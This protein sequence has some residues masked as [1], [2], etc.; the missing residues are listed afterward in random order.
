M[1]VRYN[2][3]ISPSI[4]GNSYSS[5]MNH[6]TDSPKSPKTLLAIPSKAT[7]SADGLTASARS[8]FAN[9]SHLI[10]SSSTPNNHHH[11]QR[12]PPKLSTSSLSK[13]LQAKYACNVKNY[14]TT[15]IPIQNTH[16]RTDGQIL[17]FSDISLTDMYVMNS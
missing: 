15:I 7:P 1:S 17:N 3:T 2:A 8:K 6:K 9:M 13:Q 12:K 14:T 10:T 5:M 4:S 11:S 16:G